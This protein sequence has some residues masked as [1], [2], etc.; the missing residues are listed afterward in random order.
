MKKASD[1]VLRRL[2]PDEWDEV[3][4][5]IFDS[6]NAWYQKNFSKNVFG[7]EPSAARVFPE[8]YEALDPGCCIVAECGGRIAGSCFVHPRET[9][10]SLGIMNVHPEFYGQ[11]IAGKILREIISMAEAEDKP[12]RLVSSAMNLDSFSLYTK[13]GFVP[14]AAFQDMYLP[15]PETGMDGE[16]PA[17]LGRVREATLHDVG[18]MADLEMELAYIR[19][20]KDYQH[21]L[22]NEAGI[23]HV[24][25][26]EGEAGGIDGFLCS[27]NHPGSNLLGP[28]V[29]R[30]EDDAA[31]LL[32]A[33]LDAHRG[34][35]P[36]FLLPVDA[37][38]LVKTAYSWGARNCETHFCQ[39]LGKFDGFDGIVM[40]TFMPETG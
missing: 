11:G 19:R 28:G 31:A 12:V 40:P 4:T 33:E 32:F 16:M 7:G 37:A 38:E 6:T 21:F 22:E 24:S 9:H 15:I 1:I 29:M 3:A 25:V 2:L 20:E 10:V 13:H 5:M 23:W 26:I 39:V 14:R 36:V 8:V 35:T 30:T 18:A 27:V 34:R 17:G